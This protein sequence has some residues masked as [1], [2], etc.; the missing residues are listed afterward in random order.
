MSQKTVWQT[1]CGPV[2]SLSKNLVL[3]TFSC[4]CQILAWFYI[5]LTVQSLPFLFLI[6]GDKQGVVA[7]TWDPD[8]KIR[9]FDCSKHGQ[10]K[11]FCKTTGFWRNIWEHPICRWG[12]RGNL[13]VLFMF[14]KWKASMSFI[15]PHVLSI[16]TIF[17]FCNW[18]LHYMWVMQIS[19]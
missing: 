8:A 3:E 13:H 18:K 1:I 15:H 10:W 12:W 16:N 5:K 2:R 14:V 17:L 9:T 4:S 11:Y 6:E 19:R 7:K